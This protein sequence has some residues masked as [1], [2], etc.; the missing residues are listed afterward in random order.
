MDIPSTDGLRILELVHEKELSRSGIG[1]LNN[2]FIMDEKSEVIK[3]LGGNFHT[4]PEDYW[5][6]HLLVR[7]L[8][9]FNGV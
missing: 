2:F 1:K 7:H 9:E 4:D 3:M 5:A 6:K 8:S